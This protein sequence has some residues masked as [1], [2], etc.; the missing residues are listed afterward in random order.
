MDERIRL[1]IRKFQL[2]NSQEDAMQLAAAI[3]RGHAEKVKVHLVIFLHRDTSN[4]RTHYL[5]LLNYSK[6]A[7]V[8]SAAKL[9]EDWM[10]GSEFDILPQNTPNYQLFEKIRQ[11]NFNKKYTV[12]LNE[13]KKAK[14]SGQ[15]PSL[16]LEIKEL[17][18]E[19]DL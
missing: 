18:F 7:A 9:L 1:L 10:A 12:S 19:E 14:K 13:F 2:S 11:Q 15:L 8:E 3:A 17:G 6:S 4:N 16:F 5:T